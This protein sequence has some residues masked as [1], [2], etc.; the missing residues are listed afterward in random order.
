MLE[1]MEL[2]SEEVQEILTKVPHWMIRWGNVLFLTLILLLLFLSWLIKY[3]DV[4][5]ANAIITTTIPPEKVFAKNTGRLDVLLVNDNE[6]V[7]ANQPLAVIENTAITSDVFLLKNWLDSV[8]IDGNSILNAISFPVLSV[9]EIEPAY[10]LF[11]SN[12]SQFQLHKQLK[13]YANE[14]TANLAS[15]VE[16]RSRLK[17]LESQQEINKKELELTEKNFMRVETL[18]KIG[19]ISAQEYESKQLE[20]RRSE[21]EFKQFESSISQLRESISSAQ[22]TAKGTDIE[23]IQT[24]NLLNRDVLQ[25][26]ETLKNAI[27]E[28]EKKYVL[29]SSI[30]GKVSFLDYYS[31]HQ[32][33]TSGDIIFVVIPN[34]NS[35]LTAKLKT[36]SRNSGKMRI[37]QDVQLKLDNYPDTEFGVIKGNV[38]SISEVPDQDGFYN[39]DVSLA[40]NLVTTYGKEI[41]FKQEMRAQAEVITEHLRLLERFFYQLKEKVKR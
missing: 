16:L 38:V 22:K 12:S 26:Y 13:P 19:V 21:R 4:I 28:W 14:A 15:I 24:D 40:P 18:F 31:S 6:I 30:G 25:S 36:P 35:S 2:R 29:S 39:V 23:R 11:Q 27:R 20:F 8:K 33:V 10:A 3:P 32:S 41:P 9:G 5:S 17:T 34:E 1:Q 7:K 37:G